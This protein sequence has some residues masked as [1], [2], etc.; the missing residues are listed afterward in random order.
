MTS[1]LKLEPNEPDL[2]ILCKIP[3][4]I[5]LL[6]SADEIT[7]SGKFLAVS[8]AHPVHKFSLRSPKNSIRTTLKIYILCS[9]K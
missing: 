1:L 8:L 4:K 2:L 5:G 7:S 9:I 6:S 3:A